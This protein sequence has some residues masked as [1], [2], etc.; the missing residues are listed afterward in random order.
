[1]TPDEVRLVLRTLTNYFGELPRRPDWDSP[2][3][4]EAWGQ[5]LT[6]FSLA[7]AS[8]AILD[9]RERVAARLAKEPPDPVYF[10]IVDEFGNYLRKIASR[11]ERK[12]IAAAAHDSAIRC[13]GSR[14]IDNSDAATGRR[15][16]P[17]LAEGMVACPAC[18]P[19]MHERQM[20]GDHHDPTKKGA[21]PALPPCK[22]DRSN[23]GEHVGDDAHQA[24]W[25]RAVG[26]FSELPG[27][28]RAGLVLPPEDGSN[29]MRLES[30]VAAHAA[31]RS[32]TKKAPDFLARMHLDP[33]PVMT[34][35][36]PL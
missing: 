22:P 17:A 2:G 35:T 23:P 6:P 1:M 10:P 8:S 27:Q 5:M 18:S 33:D 19:S 24:R 25:S 7:E 14:F 30:F 12:A 29:L 28:V 4:K 11:E 16:F 3:V 21:T 20:Y 15:P 36:R 34:D 26:A 32:S 31:E 13:D 9:L